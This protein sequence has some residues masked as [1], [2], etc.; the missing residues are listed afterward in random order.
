M[1]PIVLP[2]EDNVASI[3]ICD[4]CETNDADLERGY[5]INNEEICYSC[6]SKNT[7]REISSDY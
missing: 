5:G 6:R 7:M 1:R 3:G 4:T 2:K